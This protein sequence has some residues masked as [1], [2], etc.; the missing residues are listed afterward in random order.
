VGTVVVVALGVEFALTSNDGQPFALP[1]NGSV[2][3][4]AEDGKSRLT[5]IAA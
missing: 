1:H 4:Q 2:K 5:H 3:M